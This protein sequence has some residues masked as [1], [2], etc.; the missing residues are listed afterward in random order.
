M[1]PSASSES[2]LSP[3]AKQKYHTFDYS[4]YRKVFMTREKTIR[5]LDADLV[6][7]RYI[8]NHNDPTL[9]GLV[10]PFVYS[11]LRF[12]TNGSYASIRSSF[13]KRSAIRPGVWRCAVCLKDCLAKDFTIDH[14]IKQF[15][16]D[17]L[18]HS[19]WNF[20]V[21][22]GW[23]NSFRDRV[24]M[25]P[26]YRNKQLSLSPTNENRIMAVR[27]LRQAK[28]AYTKWGKN[29]TL[30]DKYRTLAHNLS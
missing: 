17:E 11:S 25:E 20:Q 30:V 12:T 13:K 22:H 6:I 15:D 26:H 5:A 10:F 21:S 1:T 8:V 16:D 14:I 29:K 24:M 28:Q 27:I 2:T 9:F 3:R 18:S 4:Q 19:P 7:L 23:C